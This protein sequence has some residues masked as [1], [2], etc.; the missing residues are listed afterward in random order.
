MN[1]SVDVIAG[2][3]LMMRKKDVKLLKTPKENNNERNKKIRTKKTHPTTLQ[4]E[5]WAEKFTQGENVMEIG[6]LFI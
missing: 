5:I 3:K 2:N 1:N 4:Y 6:G